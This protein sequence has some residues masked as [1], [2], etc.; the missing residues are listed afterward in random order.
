MIP[1]WSY[2]CQ[3]G[4][5]HKIWPSSTIESLPLN[6]MGEGITDASQIFHLFHL[7]CT[8]CHDISITTHTVEYCEWQS[9]FLKEILLLLY[10]QYG[11]QAYIYCYVLSEPGECVRFILAI[12]CVVL[13]RRRQE[14]ICAPIG[15]GNCTS[16][17]L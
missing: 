12:K 8:T 6:E 2:F 4:R 17:H 14:A 13:N 11:F 3:I 10:T 15:V 9:T 5:Y 7:Y 1:E 16:T